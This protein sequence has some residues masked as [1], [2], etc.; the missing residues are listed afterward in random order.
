MTGPEIRSK[1]TGTP[2]GASSREF[3]GR[4]E[5]HE[6]VPVRSQGIMVFDGQNYGFATPMA[7]S[8]PECRGFLLRSP[9]RVALLPSLSSLSFFPLCLTFFFLS[10]SLCAL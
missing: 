4:A 6:I 7:G 5:K 9:L 1:I 8:F 3:R 10:L 2:S